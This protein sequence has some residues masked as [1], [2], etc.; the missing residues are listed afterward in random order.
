M[1]LEVRKIVID[2]V[3]LRLDDKKMIR[4][5]EDFLSQKES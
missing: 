1:N 3:F 2:Q 4:D 5:I